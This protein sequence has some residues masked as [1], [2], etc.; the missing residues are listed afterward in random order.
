MPSVKVHIDK[1][2]P[3]KDGTCA[4][5]LVVHLNYQSMKFNTGVSCTEKEWDSENKRI[6]GK[7]KTIKDD[8]LTI[9][10]CLARMNDIFVRYRLQNADLAPETLRNEWKNPA[11]RI[12]F[13]AFFDEALKEKKGTIAHSTWIHHKSII[14]TIKL[15]KP[16]LAFADMNADYIDR[17]QRWL[18]KEQ[19]NDV[20]TIHGK[21]RVLRNYLNIAVRKGIIAE[22]PFKQVKLKKAAVNRV[23]L[24][25]DELE[26]LWNLYKSD[27]LSEPRRKILR[28]FLFMCFTGVRIS[29][30]RA[31][32]TGNIVSESLVYS[33][34]K[35]REIKKEPIVVPLNRYAMELVADEGPNPFNKLF[36]TISEQKMNEAIKE[37]VKAVEIGKEITNHSGRHTFATVWLAKTHD[38]A[39]LQALLGHSDIS[40]TMMYVHITEE[41]TKKQMKIFETELFSKNKNPLPD[42]PGE[43][44]TNI[45]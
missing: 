27:K 20:N 7:T 45:V 40:T 10:R 36:R 21:M 38:L 34:F 32:T 4:I 39:Q 2:K 35:T 29:D 42:G 26:L 14:G 15:F 6:I 25:A 1:K 28:H 22:N 8:N 3:K 19:K 17:L 31:F 43:D 24:S 30:L 18:K 9:E 44:T 33:A 13:F 11:R 23:A 37:I 41:E 16:K 12:D 5:Y